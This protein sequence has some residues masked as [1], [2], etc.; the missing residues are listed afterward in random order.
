MNSPEGDT[1]GKMAFAEKM[2]STCWNLYHM[3]PTGI[4]A[5]SFDLTGGSFK[6]VNDQNRLRPEVA[7]SLFYLWRATKKPIYRKRGWQMFQAFEHYARNP[8][9]GYCALN[10]VRRRRRDRSIL[11][12]SPSTRY[13]RAMLR[14]SDVD[15]PARLIVAA[16]RRRRPLAWRTH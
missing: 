2:C 13:L 3:T 12:R 9:G 16:R 11:D 8:Y 5:E 6:I 10:N 7:E 4:G 15:G 14:E 1:E